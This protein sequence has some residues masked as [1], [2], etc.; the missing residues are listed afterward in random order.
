MCFSSNHTTSFEV[1]LMI[2][3]SIVETSLTPAKQSFIRKTSSIYSDIQQRNILKETV[4]TFE[5]Y[6]T[7]WQPFLSTSVR[8]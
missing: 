5:K 1:F 3:H 2:F 6:P 8:M 7:M 4:L